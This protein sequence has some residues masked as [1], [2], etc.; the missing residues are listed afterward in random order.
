MI[1]QQILSGRQAEACIPEKQPTDCIMNALSL[2]YQI[3]PLPGLHSVEMYDQRRPDHCFFGGGG[4][5]Q[6]QKREK[7]LHT[8]QALPLQK[9]QL[10]W[11]RGNL[12]RT[13]GAGEESVQK[14][15]QPGV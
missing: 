2:L 5:S 11:S 14:P 9:S 10:A 13:E 1:K 12:Q 6:K 7:H 8:R 4:F 3:P 15:P